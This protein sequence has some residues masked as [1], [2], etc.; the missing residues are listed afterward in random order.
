MPPAVLVAAT[1]PDGTDPAPMPTRTACL[2]DVGAPGAAGDDDHPSALPVSA[3]ARTIGGVGLLGELLDRAESAVPT[4]GDLGQRAGC[5]GEALLADLVADLA[6]L[7]VPVDEADSLEEHEMLG[8][9]LPTD[10]HVRG[11]GRRRGLTAGN[12]EVEQLAARRIRHRLPEI[13]VI[14]WAVHGDEAGPV[15]KRSRK[16]SPWTCQP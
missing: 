12:E 16:R 4:V 15:A 11:E 2:R 9:R 5:F 8:D 6:S 7:A 1:W 13:V 10:G 14:R 3:L